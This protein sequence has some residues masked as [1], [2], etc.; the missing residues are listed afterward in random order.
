[1]PGISAEQYEASLVV[2]AVGD[3]LGAVIEF[4]S[5]PEIQRRH[6]PDGLRELP[7]PA[8]FTDDTQMTLFT[9]EGLIRTSTRLRAKGIT[10]HIDVGRYALLRWYQTQGGSADH[11]TGW[12]I[13]NDVLH[14]RRAPGNTCLSSLASSRTGT[15][16]EPINDS[17]GCGAVMRMAPVGL[18]FAGNPETA[19]SI[20]RE[21]GA[22]TH[23]HVEGY[24]SAGAF[25]AIVAG[26]ASGEPLPAAV[27]AALAIAAREARTRTVVLLEEAA[28]FEGSGS[29]DPE[30]LCA[31]LGE[32]WVG[33]EAL[34]LSVACVLAHADD[35]FE[36]MVMAVNHRG[37][38]DSTGAIAGNL[39]GLLHGSAWLPDGWSER[40]EGID[41]VRIVA[42]D[43]WTERHE[44]PPDPADPYGGPDPAWFRR[45]PGS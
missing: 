37:D 24:E 19:Y 3:A 31:R 30:E 9:A 11:A 15:V 4:A 12:L 29:I 14:R 44:P 28:G 21:L 45:Y 5:W 17:K 16:D 27:E 1:M 22:L 32:G 18:W 40:V 35:P 26:V 41:V 2:G 7:S 34:A 20:G 42:T 39:L 13:T 6:G 23:G 38:S 36:A 10:T 33:E 43:L 25:A 8:E